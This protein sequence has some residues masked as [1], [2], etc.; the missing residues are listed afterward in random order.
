MT[1]DSE[2]LAVPD[3]T[4]PGAQQHQSGTN[5]TLM[6]EGMTCASCVARVE[7]A[8][9]AVPGVT[10]ASVNFATERA[11]VHF[12]APANLDAIATAIRTAG[13]TPVTESIELAITGMTCAS[14]V[15]RLE[16][17]LKKQPGVIAA[18]VN[19][20]TE[21]ANVSYLSGAVTVEALEQAVGRAGFGAQP[22]ETAEQASAV[23]RHAAEARKLTQSF[24][25]ALVLTL[26]LVILAMAPEFFAPLQ[27]FVDAAIGLETLRIIEC[28]LATLV[29][30]GPGWRFFAKGV[31]A[32]LHGGPD[33]NA[34][35]ALGSFA[36]WSYSV[37]ATF[38]PQLF[39][40]GTAHVYFEAAAV[41]VTLILLGRVLEVGAKGRA[42]A[43][44]ERLLD[45]TP[46]TAQVM[47]NGAPVEVKLA[48]IVPGDLVFIRP[49]ERVPLDGEVVEGVSFVDQSMLTGEA[50][51]VRKSIGEE[52]V[53]G[54]INTSGSLTVKVTKIGADTVLARIV[55]MVEQAQGAKLPIQA[56]ADKVT[57]WFVPAVMGIAAVTF[58]IWLVLGPQP[59]FT[60]ALVT[61][62][63]VLIIACPCA[64]GL[65]TPTS[66]MVATGRAAELG[67]LF[68]QGAAL[69]NLRDVGIIAFDK[70]GT[71]TKGHP[72]LTDF[73]VAAGFK[74]DEVLA[75]AAAVEMHSEH[76]IGKAIVAA[77]KTRK[78]ALPT[79]ADFEATSGFGVTA[80]AGDRMI[81][82][83]ADRFMAKRGVDVTPFADLAAGLARDGK[84]PLFIAIGGSL[85]GVF[86]VAD[87]IKPS[88]VRAIAALKAQGLT[89]AM[90]SGDRQ[91]TAEAIGRRLGIEKVVAEVLPEGKVAAVETLRAGAKKLAFVGDGINDAPALAAAD[92]GI[93]V[94]T[95]T[96]IAIESA[97]VVL[98]SGELDA[99][100]AAVALSH[101]TMR[102][103]A[104]NLFWAFGYNVVL[105][106]VAAG[107]LYPAFGI[108]LSPML[109][110]GAMA[111]SSVF[112]V[113]N[114]LRL[115]RF[116]A[117]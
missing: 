9:R 27:H 75:A 116:R 71:L 79:I 29:L 20:A 54:T 7:K 103:I 10:E 39:P 6:I 113:T 42:G 8:I 17:V 56:L 57:A 94:G 33:M 89:C 41:I 84:S 25:I 106:P 34:L 3:L 48:A 53:G 81:V 74:E 59:S 60:Y 38:A 104:Q 117:A 97:D 66:I 55:K 35:V 40:A 101:A 88:A 108:L 19:L 85:A 114:A 4:S 14:C 102:N 21:R 78:L 92:V 112:V 45:L 95:G 16:R 91:A 24:V 90:V 63:A 26:P 73:S 82:L 2:T 99:V 111:F 22:L 76:P 72:E 67:I 1:R 47:R 51:P 70:T 23:H 49:G 15:S 110:A 62:V 98:M 65:A 11:D 31:P 69:Q 46:E 30:F 96:D 105:I 100:V 93:A 5:A 52:V 58:V 13:Y 12:A 44:I 61:M 80:R 18:S 37:V 32:L 68:R 109:G 50:Q 83:G 86:A 36:A 107:A 64:M 43:A 28:V 77:A 87:P 115:K